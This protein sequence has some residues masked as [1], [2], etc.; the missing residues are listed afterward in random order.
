MYDNYDIEVKKIKIIKKNSQIIISK[1][2]I[3]FSINKQVE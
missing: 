1:A 2:K 3:I